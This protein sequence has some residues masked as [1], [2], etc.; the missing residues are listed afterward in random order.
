LRDIPAES[1]LRGPAANQIRVISED[2][3]SQLIRASI[4]DAIVEARDWSGTSD[5]YDVRVV[6]SRFSGA[7][8]IDQ[9]RMVYAAVD[10]AL[11]DGRLHAIQIKTEL[12]KDVKA[13]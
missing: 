8:L 4:P 6:S 7:S 2:Q 13:S 1:E 3:L 11:K 12:P 10:P 9:H 5:H